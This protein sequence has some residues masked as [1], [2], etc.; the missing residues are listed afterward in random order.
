MWGIIKIPV[1]FLLVRL[2]F[3]FVLA[4]VP[5]IL[6]W[7]AIGALSGIGIASMLSFNPT[8]LDALV[9]LFSRRLLLGMPLLG[10]SWFVFNNL[11]AFLSLIAGCGLI[12]LGV[13]KTPEYLITS[14]KGMRSYRSRIILLGLHILPKGAAFLNAFVTGLLL[15]WSW[16][17]LGVGV[18]RI[19]ALLIPHALNELV[20]LV[21]ITS[22]V[23]AHVKLLSTLILEERWADARQRL[24]ELMGSST[25]CALI[26][27]V[28]IQVL[29]S[30][31]IEA[32]VFRLLT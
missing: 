17:R 18:V 29:L 1:E 11:L 26:L 7:L 9:E 10:T 21:L 22:L 24:K 15:T 19:I 8:Y 4:Q 32:W 30:G 2:S 16:F 23:L 14:L 12:L 20:A 6:A 28:L 27:I 3:G 5:T 25:S 13:T 31:L